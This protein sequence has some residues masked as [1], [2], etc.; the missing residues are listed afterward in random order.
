MLASASAMLV[1]GPVLL[2]VV[3]LNVSFTYFTCVHVAHLINACQL[4]VILHS[5][6][7]SCQTA[8]S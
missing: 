8:C 7:L 6:K 3:A 5:K 2:H 1:P 4:G